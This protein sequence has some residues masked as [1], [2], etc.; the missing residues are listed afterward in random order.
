[1]DEGDDCAFDSNQPVAGINASGDS[2][3]QQHEQE[4]GQADQAPQQKPSGPRYG[5][6]SLTKAVSIQVEPSAAA[7]ADAG[8]QSMRSLLMARGRSVDIPSAPADA[9]E[10]P[11]FGKR[12]EFI[13]LKNLLTGQDAVD[14][15]HNS[16][17]M[18]RQLS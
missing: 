15:L 8:S 17:V 9:P 13:R 10:A 11:M 5:K 7:P 3:E 6:S 4:R 12:K 14:T 1:M 2:Q 18:V 16:G